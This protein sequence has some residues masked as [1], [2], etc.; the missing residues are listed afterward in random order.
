MSAG[1]A[2]KVFMSTAA[3][4]FGPSQNRTQTHKIVV[5]LRVWSSATTGS[6]RSELQA[7]APSRPP[8][9]L[10]EPSSPRAGAGRLELV[11]HLHRLSTTSPGPA[12]TAWP[13]SPGPEPPARAS[14]PSG[15]RRH[16]GWSPRR[17]RLRMCRVAHPV[18]PPPSA[19]RQRERPAPRPTVSTRRRRGSPVEQQ[20]AE[21]RA[22]DRGPSGRGDALAVDGDPVAVDLDLDDLGHPSVTTYFTPAPARPRS[23]RGRS[24]GTDRMP[25]PAQSRKPGD[26]EIA[27]QGGGIAGDVDQTARQPAA[28][29]RPLTR[30]SMPVRGGFTITRSGRRSSRARPPPARV[31]RAAG[32]RARPRPPPAGPS[33]T[34]STLA[35]FRDAAAR[36]SRRCRRRGPTPSARHITELLQREGADRDH[37]SRDGPART[38]W[39]ESLV[40]PRPRPAAPAFRLPPDRDRAVRALELAPRA[41]RSRPRPRRADTHHM[42]RAA[43]AVEPSTSCVEARRQEA[44]RA[45]ATPATGPS[46]GDG[47]VAP[48]QVEHL[49]RPVVGMEPDPAA[50]RAHGERDL[51]SILADLRGRAT[52]G[53]SATSSFAEPPERVAHD[54]APGASCAS[55]CRC[56][57]WQPPHLSCDV[58]GTAGLHP[59]GRRLTIRPG[60][61]RAK[62]LSF[63]KLDQLHQVARRGAG[64][65]DRLAHQSAPDPV[66]T[67]G[68][69]DDPANRRHLSP[70][71]PAPAGAHSLDD[72]CLGRGR[73]APGAAARASSASGGGHGQVERC[74]RRVAPARGD[75][76]AARETGCRCRPSGSSGRPSAGD[77]TP[78]WWPP[79]R[80]R[81]RPARAACA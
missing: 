23:P 48:L 63:A 43:I 32:P 78:G 64:H 42:C 5:L 75:R 57:S 62:R 61:A 14:A 20:L 73:G 8:A 74:R 47:D 11:L 31:P 71:Q 36:W 13:A 4:G 3:L 46:A 79:R 37:P 51:G 77:E 9:R 29:A 65:K 12:A 21:R 72:P 30:W 6:P 15:P 67:G 80:P 81:A 52:I 76:S 53:G 19:H 69:P 18:P 33:S 59:I 1:V 2:V 10:T 55:Y 68:E 41:A 25:G 35:P 39:P 26:A 17:S 28:R 49:I 16:R 45:L 60:R 38:P 27:R 58:V 24:A 70:S 22:G 50:V 40:A 34:L 44:S 54:R 66:A 7:P 56:C